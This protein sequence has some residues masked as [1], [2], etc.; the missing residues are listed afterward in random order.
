M[1]WIVLY[2]AYIHSTYKCIA[3][4]YIKYSPFRCVY[5]Y[6][7]VAVEREKKWHAGRRNGTVYWVDCVLVDTH[8]HLHHRK[9][10]PN[11]KR[12]MSEK[13]NCSISMVWAKYTRR[14]CAW[15]FEAIHFL[16]LN[17]SERKRAGPEDERR[18]CTGIIIQPLCV[19]VYTYRTF[20][21]AYILRDYEKA[22]T[23]RFFLSSCP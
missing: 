1:C 18:R 3:D 9:K 17:A 23:A 7:S 21:I 16:Y 13:E 14:E 4:V 5:T 10:D 11:V 22:I 2:R 20:Y 15:S 6:K 12:K 19:C 8:T